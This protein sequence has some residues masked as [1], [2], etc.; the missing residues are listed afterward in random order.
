MTP[1]DEAFQAEPLPALVPGRFRSP[2]MHVVDDAL[3]ANVATDLGAALYNRR[4]NLTLLGDD[5]SEFGWHDPAFADAHPDIAA[6]VTRRIVAA[7]DAACA[8]CAVPA[9]DLQRVE[10]SA[11]LRHHGG[12]DA[13]HDDVGSDYADRAALHLTRR[14]SVA[15]FLSTE[16]VMFR[17]GAV[18]FANGTTIEPKHNRLAFWHPAQ[19][20]RVQPVECWSA[21]VLHG[22]W[23]IQGFVHG[24]P[25]DGWADR[26]ARL[27]EA[28]PT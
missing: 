12:R 21:H 19:Q 8:A 5:D 15:L 16:P 4:Q 22:R 3:P 11:V 13:W 14:L 6:T 27:R 28:P 23:T 25:P 10:L 17:G 26:L 9:F 18:E 20:H 7:L 24:A 2:L 1:G